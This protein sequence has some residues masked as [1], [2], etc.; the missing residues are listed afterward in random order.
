MAFFEFVSDNIYIFFGLSTLLFTVQYKRSNTF[1][2]YSKFGYFVVHSAVMATAF[3][4]IMFFRPGSWKNAILPAAGLRIIKRIFGFRWRVVGQ[5]HIVS[6]S[7]AV[8]LINHQSVLDLIVLAELW[9]VMERCTV[10]SKKE[11]KYLGPFGLASWLWGTIFIDRLNPG[12]AKGTINRTGEIVRMKKA[13]L[14][15]FPEGT[16]HGGDELLPFKKG[17]FHV[18]VESRLPIQPVVVSKYYYIDHKTKTFESGESIIEILPPIPTD[19]YSKDNVD[20]LI[21]KTYHIM[22][23]RYKQLNKEV[24]PV[25]ENGVPKYDLN[26]NKKPS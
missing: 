6:D 20:Q 17:A 12:Q 15:M 7:G 25:V 10:I 13:K 19:G 2:Y 8:V 24:I 26:E 22:S 16:R 1:R 5:E 23:N 14:L 21:D 11:V 4:P 9:K 18:A 3:L